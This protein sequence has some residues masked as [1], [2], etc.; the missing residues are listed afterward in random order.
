MMTQAIDAAWAERRLTTR[1]PGPTAGRGPIWC[2]GPATAVFLDGRLGL[3]RVGDPVHATAH[4]VRGPGRARITAANAGNQ[5]RASAG[6]EAVALAGD[7][8]DRGLGD[9]DP[10]ALAKL[11]GGVL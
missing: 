11:A 7:V 4:I 1:W 10:V 5:F 3:V 6:G 8:E 9:D 2:A